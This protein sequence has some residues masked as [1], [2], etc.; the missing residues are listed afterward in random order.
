MF[1]NPNNIFSNDKNQ[2]I[3]KNLDLTKQISNPNFQNNIKTKN[4]ILRYSPIKEKNF[5]SLYIKQNKY[6]EYN[7]YDNSPMKENKNLSLYNQNNTEYNS[8]NLITPYKNNIEKTYNLSE[9]NSNP[10]QITEK[11]SKIPFTYNRNTITYVNKNNFPDINLNLDNPPQFN[12]QTENITKNIP[13]KKAKINM[14]FNNNNNEYLTFVNGNYSMLEENFDINDLTL[15]QTLNLD[16]S[17]IQNSFVYN[18]P[19]SQS[20]AYKKKKFITYNTNNINK[21]I[22]N[23]N[24]NQIIHFRKN[25]NSLNKERESEIYTINVKKIQRIF[26]GY[27]GRKKFH[28]ITKIKN[29]V[30]LAYNILNFYLKKIIFSILIKIK[31]NNN[32]NEIN[33]KPIYRKK[34]TISS[35]K[36]ERFSIQKKS[37]N[38]EG[39][40]LK[41][42]SAE[43]NI[44]EQLK[45]YEL[46]LSILKEE[47]K[48]L[49]TL[50]NKRFDNIKEI[51]LQNQQ[52]KEKNN[53]LSN[54]SNK[55]P[56]KISHSEDDNNEN[57]PNIK[58]IKIQNN[59]DLLNSS[60]DVTNKIY[61]LKNIHLKQL[62]WKKEK[63]Y[64]KI[65]TKYLTKWFN[66]IKNDYKNKEL[67]NK[68]QKKLLK[69]FRS[70]D[71]YFFLFMK[72]EF[73]KFLFNG[74]MRENLYLRK[75]QKKEF[76][77]KV[78]NEEKD[79]EVKKRKLLRFLLF[80]KIRAINNILI[81][82]FRKF[83]FNGLYNHMKKE[84]DIDI[85]KSMII[86]HN[87]INKE[88]KNDSFIKDNDKDE[89]NEKIN[90]DI[91]NISISF[92]NDEDIIHIINSDDY[93]KKINIMKKIVFKKIRKNKEFLHK[94][95]IKFYYRGIYRELVYKRNLSS[96]NT[97][98][99]Q[100]II[101]SI[102]PNSNILNETIANSNYI[103]NNN[104]NNPDIVNSEM[105]NYSYLQ[106]SNTATPTIN[107]DNIEKEKKEEQTNKEEKVNEIEKDI[108]NDIKKEEII[109]ER[110]N[111]EI[112]KNNI[113]KRLEKAKNLRK[114]LVNKEKEKKETLKIHFY[115]FYKAGIIRIMRLKGR[116]IKES[117]LNSITSSKIINSNIQNSNINENKMSLIT[118][119]S[120]KLIQLKNNELIILKLDDIVY[121]KNRKINMILKNVL[122]KWNLKAN[123]FK[124]RRTHS[125]IKRRKSSSKNKNISIN[126]S[127][128][129]SKKVNGKK[130]IIN[131]G[132]DK[133][134]KVNLIPKKI[135]NNENEKNEINNEEFIKIIEK[136]FLIYNKKFFFNY[137]KKE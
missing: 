37:S 47:N 127:P 25:N 51:S 80:G 108:K 14:N 74:I 63:F 82:K 58:I 17:N 123:L 119:N 100:T 130:K 8:I 124:L 38:N 68:R 78:E 6:S 116:K 111:E 52:L 26:R 93:E 136:I 79:D 117:K 19:K 54:D 70:K 18:S 46:E 134:K 121:K 12:Q 44:H 118:E 11:K 92:N 101:N 5:E 102:I 97:I 103:N 29:N 45:K 120:L 85:R 49:R 88:K 15:N 115:N 56:E 3:T 96:S 128:E 95:F 32:I 1:Q 66:I 21:N 98:E 104:I 33:Q 135:N 90:Y 55:S 36:I 50:N 125:E 40:I 67:I 83:Y 48:Q 76:L 75:E 27:L 4:N 7:T 126:N 57:E 77:D 2:G 105:S 109:I 73:K 110:N 113:A 89:I 9:R 24:K 41:K 65:L 30:N 137:L 53:I 112:E 61:K 28:Y 129:S 39:K 10:Y 71:N 99:K 72:E 81:Q 42:E 22:Y 64:H 86:E 132:K 114:H 106:N 107:E 131:K 13:Y 84:K 35:N 23:G 91:I 133:Q 34:A 69:Y 31:T 94:C 60:F 87:I 20:L 62:F 16:N 59:Q 43:I 122:K